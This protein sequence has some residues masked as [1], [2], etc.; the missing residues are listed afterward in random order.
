MSTPEPMHSTAADLAA[1]VDSDTYARE[2]GEQVLVSVYQV[3]HHAMTEADLDHAADVV[4]QDPVGALVLA[5]RLP[6]PEGRAD[7]REP[8]AAR[9]YVRPLSP[10]ELDRLAE[11]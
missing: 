5:L 2:L 11:R 7:L 6:P 8:D 10:V 9:R 4:R 1:L 3:P